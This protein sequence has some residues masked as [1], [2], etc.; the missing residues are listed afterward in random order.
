MF[1][2]VKLKTVPHNLFHTS[3]A[4]GLSKQVGH[5]LGIRRIPP[6][7]FAFSLDVHHM[8]G[9][10]KQ[11]WVLQTTSTPNY[12]QH[13][14]KQTILATSQCQTT[15]PPKET[16]EELVGADVHPCFNIMKNRMA[17]TVLWQC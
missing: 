10:I 7:R 2:K 8:V 16:P 15:C 13:L 5:I 14:Q 1:L 9:A 11:H 3:G 6:L 12:H 4:E 17:N